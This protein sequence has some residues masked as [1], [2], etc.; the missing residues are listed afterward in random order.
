MSRAD[1]DEEEGGGRRTRRNEERG[2][3][4]RKGASLCGALAARC[5][6]GTEALSFGPFGITVISFVTTVGSIPPGSFG[7][8][9]RRRESGG[10]V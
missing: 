2:G 9:R 7:L 3:T 8:R 6:P 5:S 10:I 4:R 1:E